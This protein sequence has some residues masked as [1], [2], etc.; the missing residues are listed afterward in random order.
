MRRRAMRAI[1]RASARVTTATATATTSGRGA[2]RWLPE[3]GR[4]RAPTRAG[5]TVGGRRAFASDGDVRMN[6]G[7]F[8]VWGAN[9][10]VGKTLVSGG[11]ARAA[12]ATGTP[13]AFLKPVQTGFPED[14]DAEF[15]AR[16]SGGVE[17]MGEHASVAANASASGPL[18]GKGEMWAHTEFAWRRAAGPHVSAVE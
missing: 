2:G 3:V 13:A 18:G 4:G 9:T 6:V 5:W 7:A 17:S 15:V 1:A 11:L 12:R 8:V 16:V 10:G 14:S